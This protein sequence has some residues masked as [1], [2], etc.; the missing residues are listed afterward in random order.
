MSI[1]RGLTLL[2][3]W[4]MEAGRWILHKKGTSGKICS[5]HHHPSA[6]D[7]RMKTSVRIDTSAI[8]LC[9]PMWCAVAV[10]TLYLRKKRHYKHHAGNK[11]HTGSRQ[12]GLHCGCFLGNVVSCG[13]GIVKTW[14]TE[15]ETTTTATRGGERKIGVPFLQ[16]S[17]NC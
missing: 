12:S 16:Y 5:D 13:K 17:Q 8:A 14:S 2:R 9:I 4:R 10:L 3:R 7:I 15:M 11:R 6:S 1:V